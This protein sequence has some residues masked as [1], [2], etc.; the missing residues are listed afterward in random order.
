MA[1][2][3]Y[4]LFLVVAALVLK[5][6]L[7]VSSTFVSLEQ[8]Q[9]TS[10]FQS[11]NCGLYTGMSS[12]QELNKNDEELQPTIANPFAKRKPG[13]EAPRVRT[14]IAARRPTKETVST[15]T[16]TDKIYQPDF[17]VSQAT[18]RY[19]TMQVEKNELSNEEVPTIYKLALIISGVFRRNAPTYSDVETAVLFRTIEHTREVAAGEVEFDLVRHEVRT[20]EVMPKKERLVFWRTVAQRIVEEWDKKE[21]A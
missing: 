13:K 11:V 3:A 4:S 10:L 5:L 6:F 16:P 17:Y 21:E 15:T 7:V 9:R 20:M 14:F 8:Y 1:L 2:V 19:I 18:Q 12:S